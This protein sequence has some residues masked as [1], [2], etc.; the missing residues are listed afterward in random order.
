MLRPEKLA[1]HQF[2][3]DED[4][5][6]DEVGSTVTLYNEGTHCVNEYLSSKS[7]VINLPFIYIS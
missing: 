5:E 1:A 7:L 6:K 2:E 4:V 3:V